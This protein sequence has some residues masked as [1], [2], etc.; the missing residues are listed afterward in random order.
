MNIV[1]RSL[2]V[3]VLAVLLTACAQSPESIKPFAISSAPYA[4]LTCPQ[5]SEYK[6]TLAAAYDKAADTEKDARLEDAAGMVL[7]GVP[8]GSATHESLPWQIGDLK[9]RIA[10]VQELQVKDSCGE[11]QTASN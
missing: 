3:A 8:V 7:I 6:A 11:E 4:Y 1:T 9:G 10:A 2:P 5:L